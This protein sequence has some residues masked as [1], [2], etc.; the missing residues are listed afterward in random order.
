MS[1]K[2]HENYDLIQINSLLSLGSHVTLVGRT[3]HFDS[4]PRNN[5]VEV[6]ELPEWCF[7][8]FCHLKPLCYRLQEILT[9][10]YISYK[11]SPKKY[12]WTILLCYDILS[13]FF[14]RTK[15]KVILIDHNNVGQLDNR[16]KLLLT[17]IYPDYAHIALNRQMLTRLQELLPNHKVRYIP[18]GLVPSFTDK[19]SSEKYASTESF[20]FCP[21]NQNF[22]RVKVSSLFNSNK[23]L[24]YLNSQN[25]VF[26]V[27]YFEGIRED[28]KEMQVIKDR[29]NDDDYKYLIKNSIAV[30]LPYTEEFRY[31][32]S[33]ILFECVANDTTVICMSNPA[34]SIYKDVIDMYEF[35]NAKKL[36]ECIEQRIDN[37]KR[38]CDKNLLS[39]TSYWKDFLNL[40]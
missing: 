22:D 12:D 39:P 6:K 30:I 32:C 8:K 7:R 2:G 18:H 31:R 28:R 27:K 11:F 5:N 37:G 15:S 13:T 34:T 4:V 3:G 1:P 23:F 10:L 35:E 38:I 25:I 20:V 24:D 33:G 29:I 26:Y 21:V 36:I 9:L 14:F 40:R 17:K 16:L 19:L